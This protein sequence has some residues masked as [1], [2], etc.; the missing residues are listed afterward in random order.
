VSKKTSTR[1]IS[2]IKEKEIVIN[3]K[4]ISFPDIVILIFQETKEISKTKRISIS[5]DLN[6][7]NTT[8]INLRRKTFFINF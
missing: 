4:I 5:Q 3:Q 7:T 2:T 1:I 8:T 6:I